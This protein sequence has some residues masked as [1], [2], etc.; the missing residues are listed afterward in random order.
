LIQTGFDTY[1]IYNAGIQAL[2]S[3]LMSRDQEESTLIAT[4]ALELAKRGHGQPLAQNGLLRVL[5]MLE[6]DPRSGS[7]T[8]SSE[9]LL[10]IAK[11]MGMDDI[12]VLKRMVKELDSAAFHDFSDAITSTGSAVY[13]GPSRQDR[14]RDDEFELKDGEMEVFDPTLKDEDYILYNSEKGVFP[15]TV[16]SNRLKDIRMLKDEGVIGDVE[17]TNLKRD[18]LNDI[19]VN[20]R[21]ECLDCYSILG[22]PRGASD[23]QIR[24]AY[25]D[26]ATQ[27]HPDKVSKL[28]PRLKE[29]ASEEMVRL[30]HAKDTLLNP[31]SRMKHDAALSMDRDGRS[32]IRS[33][34]I[35]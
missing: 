8:M 19:R 20:I 35:R 14:P 22:V 12:E 6:G 33:P 10:A 23:A 21:L 32:S 1:I 15:F 2:A 4:V 24:D 5:F 34:R 18:I 29:V 27:Y 17:Y 9:Y 28:G 31:E 30:N 16:L 13:S 7:S 26:L 3:D 11:C 25:K